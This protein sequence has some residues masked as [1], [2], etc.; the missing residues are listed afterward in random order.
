V[1][2]A[3]A[4]ATKWRRGFGEKSPFDYSRLSIIA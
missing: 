3:L 2:T 4:I 1:G